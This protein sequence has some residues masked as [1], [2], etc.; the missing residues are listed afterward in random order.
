MIDIQLSITRLTDKQMD[1]LCC[2][3]FSFSYKSIGKA[4]S[5]SNRTV[6]GHV[7]DIISKTHASGKEDII[8]NIRMPKNKIIYENLENRF[9]EIM[10]GQETNN[11]LKND[12]TK[13][14][15][16]NVLII[17]VLASVTAM[18][19]F[20]F[21][22][23]DS[24]RLMS[25]G[26]NSYL[27]GRNNL[28]DKISDIARIGSNTVALVGQGG[29]G[30]TTIAREYLRTCGCRIAYEINAETFD[31]LRENMIGLA[32][33]LART[34]EQ[35]E[36]LTFINGISNDN[37][38]IKQ[39][40]IFIY[41]RLREE[42]DWCL[43]FDNVDNFKI[44][45]TIYPSILE[46]LSNGKIIIT[47]RDHNISNYLINYSVIEVGEL[48]EAEK[49]DLFTKITGREITK[50]DK[51]HMA[52]IP[53]YP[54]DVSSIA[55]YVKN[56][57]ISLAEYVERMRES[58]VDFC[59]SNKSVIEESINYSKTR[60][61]IISSTLSRLI[62][63]NVQ[64]KEILFTIAAMDSQ[65]IQMDILKKAVNNNI[66]NDLIFYL[67][68]YGVVTVSKDNISIHRTTQVIALNYLFRTMPREE[69]N[70]FFRKITD[71][72]TPYEKIIDDY[73][74]AEKLIPHLKA[75]A[76]HLDRFDLQ[77]E[78]MNLLITLGLLLKSRGVSTFD[79][80][81]YFDKALQ[82]NERY[83]LLS[84]YEVANVLLY[85]GEACVISN[86][87]D[88]ARS[89]LNKSFISLNF[90]EQFSIEYAKNYNLLGVVQMRSNQ[91]R[92]ANGNFNNSLHALKST[93]MHSS[94]EA[95][96]EKA[97]SYANKGMS[98]ILYYINKPEVKNAITLMEESIKIIGNTDNI[99]GMKVLA[100][101]KIKM[102][103]IYNSIKEYKRAMVFVSEAEELLRKIPIKDNEYFCILGSIFME[104]GHANL[105]LNKLSEAKRSFEK[106][107]ELF[108]KTMIG[109]HSLR[110]RMQEAET[111]VR[112]GEFNQAYKNCID[113][114]DKRN[115]ERNDYNELFFNTA[116][117][118]AGVIQYKIGV[119]EKA[120]RHFQD[121][122][123]GM[124]KFC[125]VFLSQEKYAKLLSIN[126]F[127]II[128]DVA[129]LKDCLKN[130]LN[131]YREVCMEGSEFVADYVQMNYEQTYKSLIY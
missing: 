95:R 98:Y 125:K 120:L 102:A 51:K 37:E 60:D 7:R 91:F 105:R 106:A 3:L 129:R 8:K 101:T 113:V 39:I 112:L 97:T 68:K 27:L 30:K 58:G 131:I 115:R 87:N 49:I 78:K 29:S 35:K 117:Y 110:L 80:V 73:R 5:I 118:N 38:R 43:V 13:K 61:S 69:I 96:I 126:A 107:R 31:V 22:E 17:L 28:L 32:Y 79:S 93:A 124:E 9:H 6:E 56:I 66:L 33:V 109:D 47:T 36:D 40:S 127:E 128:D 116:H 71:I 64:F 1:V 89:Y 108:D 99:K 18:G 42:K 26:I 41:Y 111:L 114:L 19:F 74:D 100:N 45:K 75:I 83:H 130:A 67:N 21:F 121:F 82:L 15:Y 62:S 11:D 122:A 59:D 14:S 54:L 104:Q 12:F 92:E 50:D 86:K 24:L 48:T 70:R 20:Y 90:L 119:Y 4:L 65:N 23:N 2:L 16:K 94:I 103:S 52:E 57:N 10:A 81:L 34:Q 44:L 46:Q 77:K 85:A 84:P 76:S 63:I 88:E 25:I 72:L 55:Y 123:T 53:S